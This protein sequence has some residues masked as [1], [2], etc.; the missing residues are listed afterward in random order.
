MR[1]TRY[2]LLLAALAFGCHGIQSGD[3]LTSKD[4][5][6]FRKLHLVDN[7]ERVYQFYSEFKKSVAGNFYTEKRLASYW[8]DERDSSKN[9]TEYA[10]YEDI[11]R[12]DTCYNP[13]L[14]Y[15]PFLLV[16]RKDSSTFKV[17]ADGSKAEIA[18]F[19]NGAIN[20]WKSKN[21]LDE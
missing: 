3:S 9:K 15:A 11:I 2:I 12:I 13:G 10:F 21:K 19:F 6:R 8:I 4:F 1:S 5:R 18:E 16:T 20:K 14:T 17:C 7:G